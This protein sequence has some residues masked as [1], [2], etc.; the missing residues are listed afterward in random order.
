MFQKKNR[1]PMSSK[2]KKWWIFGLILL[3]IFVFLNR[4]QLAQHQ[5]SS[6]AVSDYRWLTEYCQTMLF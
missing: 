6:H 1:P 3:T 4:C 5:N 2:E